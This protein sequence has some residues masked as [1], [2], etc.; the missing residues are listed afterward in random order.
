MRFWRS[1]LQGTEL[2]A[3]LKR[4]HELSERKHTLLFS[5]RAAILT[6]SVVS[7]S[8]FGFISRRRGST[9][10]NAT[11]FPLYVSFASSGLIGYGPRSASPG[12]PDPARLCSRHGLCLATR[13]A[14]KSDSTKKH[15][16]STVSPVARLI[17]HS[18]TP[19]ADV[20]GSRR[21]RIDAP[22]STGPTVHTPTQLHHHTHPAPDAA[23]M[24]SPTSASTQ[25]V[26]CFAHWS[27][28]RIDIAHSYI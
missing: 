14:L 7:A 2:K 6:F 13:I 20:F 4:T 26:K 9:M 23:P 24:T 21:S 8:S 15:R 3:E 1:S 19:A 10:W 18:V 16:L 27:V 17:S 5:F 28:Q 25:S 11:L 12:G 22:Y